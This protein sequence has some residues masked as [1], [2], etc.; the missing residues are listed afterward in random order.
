MLFRQT[1]IMTDT[2]D[3]IILYKGEPEIIY[4]VVHPIPKE[5]ENIEYFKE[6]PLGDG[7]VPF[8]NYL[9][10]LDDI[11]YCGFLTIEREVGENPVADIT[12]ASDFLVDCVINGTKCISPAE[13]GIEIKSIFINGAGGDVNHVN[14]NAKDGEPNDLTIP[15]EAFNYVGSELKKSDKWDMVMQGAVK[16]SQIAFPLRGKGDRLRWMRI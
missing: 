1:L 2:K 8:E 11:G 4:G 16:K 9:K 13:D 6:V 14:V 5:I 15:G 10:A 7:S 3:G 12:K